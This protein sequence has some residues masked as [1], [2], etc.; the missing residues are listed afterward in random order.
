M[1]ARA[2]L[3]GEHFDLRILETTD[4]LAT[5]PL[6]VS[7]GE[8]GCAVLFRYGVVVL[9][10]LTPLEEV[11]FL[12]QLKPLIVDPVVETETEE[13][14][15]VLTDIDTDQAENGVIRLPEFT[16]ERLQI[17]ADALAKSTVLSYYEASI[18]EVF[19][20]IGPLATDL[21][22][23][24]RRSKDRELLRQIGGILLIEQKMV[25]M[26]EVGDKPETLWERPELER[27]YMRLEDEY[28]LRERHLSQ[29][30]KLALITR[31]AETVLNLL[32]HN[33][34]MRV[35]WYIVAL[36]L[37]EIFLSLYEM[38]IRHA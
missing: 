25:G 23:R 10:E 18:A 9:F 6:M 24:R 11:S 20:S 29:E 38:F 7:A 32:Q 34:G 19:D 35:E 33:S 31:T 22:R 4:R 3:L 27:L 1:R 36:I 15:I 8:N 12:N 14:D 17:V 26:V 5:M 21:G 16:L 30:R 28:E 13:A 37:F 2:L